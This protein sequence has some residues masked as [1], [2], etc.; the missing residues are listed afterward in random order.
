MDLRAKKGIFLGYGIG[1]KGYKFYD[2]R[3]TRVIHMR[4]VIFDELASTTGEQSRKEV[5]NQ[6]QAEIQYQDSN[7]NDDL[8]EKSQETTG[9]RRSPRDMKTPQR[10]GKW[11]YIAHNI[12]DPLTME[13]ALSIPEKNQWMK[14]MK[15]ETDSL[16]TNKVR[17]LTDLP[18]DHKAIGSKWVFKRKYDANGNLEHYKAR[19]VAQF[20][21]EAWGWLWWD[22][23]SSSKVWINTNHYCISG[24]TWLEAT[25]VRHNNCILKW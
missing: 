17:D 2:T 10:Y 20:S 18:K 11:V 14:A 3:E 21:S 4:D 8:D 12:N 1:V 16:H 24:K 7:N 6:P 15:S 9:L 5:I 19:L 13:E 22:I 23:L 25:S